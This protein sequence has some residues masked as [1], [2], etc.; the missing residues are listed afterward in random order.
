MARLSQQVRETIKIAAA[1]LIVGALL[2]F[3]WIYPLSRTKTM[4]G[5]ADLDSY[6]V[7][8]TLLSMNDPRSFSDSSVVIDT[9]RV[10][11]D[12]ST[13]LA[14]LYLRARESVSLRGTVLLIHAER[15]DRCSL[16]SLS[17]LLTNSGFGV[18]AYDQR[19]SGLSTGKYHGDGR[20]ESA[21]LEAVIGYLGL[22]NQLTAP[23]I[24]AGWKLGADAALVAASEEKRISA[25]LAV[26]PYLSSNRIIDSY[27]AEFSSWWFPLYRTAIWFWYNAR[28]SYGLEYIDSDAIPA[29]ASHTVVMVADEQRQS[30][31]IHSLIS[32]SGSLL[33]LAATTNDLNKLT[34]T[35]VTLATMSDS[36][37]R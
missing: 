32:K 20:M 2:F 29:V 35:I 25:V 26:E 19:G 16:K 15:L 3:Y 5:R 18:V 7:D 8:S 23:V 24:V 34:Q 11:S 6:Q 27:R 14:C 12:G 4:W 36:T 31:E 1:V 28:S 21:D 17:E 30:T 10:E 13:T 37:N 22:H 9:F 33:T